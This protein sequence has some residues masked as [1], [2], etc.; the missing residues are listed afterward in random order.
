VTHYRGHILIAGGAGFLGSHLCTRFIRDG[1]RV[2]CVD[3]FSTGRLSNIE[4]LKDESGLRVKS[5]DAAHIQTPADSFDAILHFASPASP[6][7]FDR[8]SL[9]ILKV[10]SLAT[11]RLLEIANKK[12]CRFLFAS[13][14]AV[15]GNPKVHPQYENYSGNVDPVGPRSVYD[16]AKRFSESLCTA[17][18]KS[19]GV[20]VRIARIFNT[21][22][23][24]MRSD[25]GR[26][27][28]TIARQ[29]ILGLPITVTGDGSQTRS[30][31]YV[32]D[33]VNGIVAL[34]NSSYN[35][36]VNLG[37]PGEISLLRLAE[38][39]KEIA[40]SDSVITFVTR[41]IGDPERRCPDISRAQSVLNWKPVQ[42]VREGL[43]KTVRWYQDNLKQATRNWLRSPKKGAGSGNSPAEPVPGSAFGSPGLA[44]R[45]RM[46]I[47]VGWGNG[48]A[49]RAANVVSERVLPS[50]SW[51]QATRSPAGVVQMPRS[52]CAMPS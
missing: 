8:L 15:Y 34:L 19:H 43:V 13:S 3:N 52:S 50:G 1:W 47:G 37:N 16:E 25:D 20:D 46:T 45:S 30:F 39:I 5:A 27:V 44:G 32:D 31:M 36:P 2:L 33:L 51:N 4:H 28:P 38:T 21:F 29:A 41:P 17:Y 35:A 23:E 22:G 18:H 48:T 7:D 42:E 49:Y 14:S 6:V 24:R 40:A 26:A 12:R 11:M 9:E 10:N